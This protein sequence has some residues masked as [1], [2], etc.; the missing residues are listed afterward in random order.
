[1]PVYTAFK[2]STL[3]LAT[4]GYKLVPNDALLARISIYTPEIVE[5]VLSEHPEI[6]GSWLE[7]LHDKYSSLKRSC[8]FENDPAACFNLLPLKQFEKHFQSW[9][10]DGIITISLPR[11]RAI[12]IKHTRRKQK[13][14]A[15]PSVLADQAAVNPHFVCGTCSAAFVDSE[16][17]SRHRMH[18]AEMEK[19]KALSQSAEEKKSAGKQDIPPNPIWWLS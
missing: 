16:Q 4:R 10:D 1:M 18:E 3:G 8:E 7:K 11:G 12:R 13:E 15:S 6:V 9:Q 5:A 17:Y 2:D 14:V 19:K